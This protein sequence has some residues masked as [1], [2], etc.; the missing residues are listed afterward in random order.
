MEVLV[1]AGMQRF[2]FSNEIVIRIGISAPSNPQIQRQQRRKEQLA[3]RFLENS[4]IVYELSSKKMVKM[5][6]WAE[7]NLFLVHIRDYRRSAY[8]PYHISE[9]KGIA[10][11]LDVWR[12]MYELVE[13]INQ[14]VEEMAS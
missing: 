11:T 6:M 14:D 12:K 8:N 1:P 2:D 9:P 4:E 7:K 13:F 5:G 10:L 3:E